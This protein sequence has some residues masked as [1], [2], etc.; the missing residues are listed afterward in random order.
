VLA[1]GSVAAADETKKVVIPFDFVSQFDHGKSGEGLGDTVWQK[2]QRRGGYVL[3][4]SMLDVRDTCEANHIHLSPET[5]LDD[6]RKVVQGT[7]AAQIG[8]WGSVELAPGEEGDV[9]DVVIKCVDFSA[10]GGPKTLY[11]CSART[12]T[13]GEIPHVYVKAL[14]DALCGSGDSIPGGSAAAEEKWKKNPNLLGSDGFEKGARG[15][16][17]GWEAVVGRYHEP[18]GQMVKWMPEPG[19]ASNH[20]IRFQFGKDVAGNEGCFYYS[21][22]FPVEEG[23][24]YRFQ[25]R[26]MTHGP[27]VKVFI[28]CYDMLPTEFRRLGAAAST[29]SAMERRE[30]YRS[31]EN[32][33]GPKNVWNTHTEDFSPTHTMYSPKFGRVM[34]YA[35]QPPGIVDWDDV[36]IKKIADAPSQGQLAGKVKRRSK[37]TKVTEP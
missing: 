11:E 35:Y 16:P 23:A 28:K 25:C 3:P 32:L 27:T 9:Y 30:I 22:A 17:T 6:V 7:F 26:F 34:L 12:K 2:L 21:L 15:I 19:N 10:P 24:T 33:K 4:E 31:Q 36:V 14:I 18:L 13:A 29:S 20:I 8:V 5:P 37:E 1:A